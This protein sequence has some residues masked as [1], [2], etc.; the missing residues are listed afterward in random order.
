M[1][2]EARGG[3]RGSPSQA[4]LQQRRPHRAH[5]LT[6]QVLRRTVPTRRSPGLPCPP[7][8][9]GAGASTVALPPLRP[10]PRAPRERRR[11]QSEP[12]PRHKGRLGAGAARE[13]GERDVSATGCFSVTPEAFLKEWKKRE[14]SCGAGEGLCEARVLL[15]PWDGGGLAP[16]GLRSCEY[17]RITAE[18]QGSS[19]PG[20]KQD[21]HQ[22][23]QWLICVPPLLW[24]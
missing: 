11:A 20:S 15:A 16:S 14:A 8:A 17:P 10:Q 2:A 4:R 1:P 13:G 18:N 23:R 5:I 3:R 6:R 22:P 9:A 7:D 21:L 12:R 19:V 24:S